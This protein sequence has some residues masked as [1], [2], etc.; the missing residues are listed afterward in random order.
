MTLA[1]T[2]E[3]LLSLYDDLIPNEGQYKM[4]NQ[5][6]GFNQ[7]YPSHRDDGD[8][9]GEDDDDDDDGDDANDDDTLHQMMT[10]SLM[11]VEARSA[12]ATNTAVWLLLRSCIIN[13]S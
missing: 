8:D 12:E 5:I 10:R 6:L 2:V 3:M 7:Q 4:S 11:K 13:A 9:N 1:I